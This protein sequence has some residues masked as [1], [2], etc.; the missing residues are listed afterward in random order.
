[1][2]RFASPSP[3]SSSLTAII[4]LELASR[5]TVTPRSGIQYLAP[6]AF[7]RSFRSTC[8]QA[9]PRTHPSRL[10]LPAPLQKPSLNDLEKS[11]M[12]KGKGGFYAVKE[13]RKPGVYR[14]WYVAI[15]SV[16]EIVRVCLRRPHTPTK[17]LD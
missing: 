1:M 13:G 17:Y 6:A 7:S 5:C 2:I 8:A 9:R 10:P 4:S 11:D 3:S 14:T 15:R 16:R 12:A